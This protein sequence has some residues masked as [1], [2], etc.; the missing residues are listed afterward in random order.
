MPKIETADCRFIVKEGPSGSYIEIELAG[1]R[2]R[3]L[4]NAHLILRF[5]RPIGTVEAHTAARDLN[6]R[7]D[8]LSLLKPD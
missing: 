7:F 6:T 3:W 5:R 1:D 8:K 2:P 4:G